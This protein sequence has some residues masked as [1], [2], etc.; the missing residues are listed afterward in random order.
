MLI[1]A[2]NI[3]FHVSLCHFEFSQVSR[4]VKR[5][6]FIF[7][8]LPKQV[9]YPPIPESWCLKQECG[10]S[11]IWLAWPRGSYEVE[12]TVLT[13]RGYRPGSLGTSVHSPCPQR[14]HTPWTHLQSLLP[15][16]KGEGHSGIW[17]PTNPWH[18]LH[19]PR[20]RRQELFLPSRP[21]LR[22]AAPAS[23]HVRKGRGPSEILL[24]TNPASE[25]G[26]AGG[27]KTRDLTVRKQVLFG[28][29]LTKCPADT[30]LLGVRTIC[31][32]PPAPPAPRTTLAHNRCSLSISSVE[33]GP[34][35]Q[36]VSWFPFKLVS[37][38]TT[39]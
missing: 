31:S 3:L 19:F 10:F 13:I 27:N 30:E 25:D 35:S 34:P 5:S 1:L 11:G 21:F 37:F 29:V 28:C 36:R 14:P 9:R 18:P 23:H 17:H 22:M 26:L 38:S 16:T 6:L 32:L 33:G 2:P 39:S 7:V 20:A 12:Y 15:A 4:C 8:T 24:S